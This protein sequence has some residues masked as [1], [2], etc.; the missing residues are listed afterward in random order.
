MPSLT[1][2]GQALV[3]GLLAGGLYALLALGLSLSWGLLR[4]VNLA[5]FALALLGAYLTYQLGHGLHL[6]PWLAALAIVPAFFLFGVALHVVFACFRVSEFTS[7]LVTFGLTVI[8]EAVIQWFWTADFRRY[9]TPYGTASLRARP[10]LRAGARAGR[11]RDGGGA[12]ARRP[13]RGSASPMSAR[14]C[15]P[16]RRIPASRRRSA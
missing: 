7:L 16:P 6:P 5:H 11:V 14:R 4:L 10:A 2:L 1:L 9:E 13:G 3:S 15:A 8:I 12:G